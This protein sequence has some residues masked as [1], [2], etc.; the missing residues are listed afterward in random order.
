MSQ[1]ADLTAREAEVIRIL[2]VL[3]SNSGKF[4]VVVG[5]AVS[6]LA[7]HRFSVDCDIVLS[8]KELESFAKVLT[9]EGYRKVRA[10]NF[11]KAIHGAKT[12]KYVKMIGGRRVA[13]D[14]YTNSLLS[15]NT[16]GEWSYDKIVE[17][18]VETNVV[19][20]VDSTMARVPKKELLI[21]MKLHAARDTDIR[22]IVMLGEHADW[23]SVADFADTGARRKLMSQL[24]LGI[25]KIRSKE[26]SSSL[27]AEFGLR[28]DVLPR[29]REHLH[30]V[31]KIFLQKQS[32]TRRSEEMI[33]I[34]QKE[35][36][37]RWLC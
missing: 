30:A 17:N 1:A 26:F 3:R 15:R 33:G 16:G 7:Q 35:V 11:P 31:Q 10:T 5:Y 25:D 2:R 28:I 32:D 22:D 21:A 4:V 13:V 37:R 27:K 23:N 29:I 19:G 12:A 36:S 34:H 18:S 8:A 20:V 6:A 24:D 9:N 14:V